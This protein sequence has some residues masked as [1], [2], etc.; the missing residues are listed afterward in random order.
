MLKFWKSP[1]YSFSKY[2]IFLPFF[3]VYTQVNAPDLSMRITILY[4]MKRWI[5]QWNLFN[6]VMSKIRLL[7]LPSAIAKILI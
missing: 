5:S 4:H 3:N 2:S 7:Y 1:E 6:N